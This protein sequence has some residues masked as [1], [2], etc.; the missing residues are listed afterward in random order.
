MA[1]ITQE[2]RIAE[3]NELNLFKNEVYSNLREMQTK[4][5]AKININH[6][7]LIDD[8]EEQSTKMNNLINNNKDMVLSMVSQKLN[9]EKIAE[10]ES[11]K[12]KLDSMII[13]HEV[14][15]KNNIEEISRIKF[16]ESGLSRFTIILDFLYKTI[17]NVIIM[18]YY[19]HK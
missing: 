15:I 10:L 2:S 16:G 3:K 7:K 11:F 14:R 9:L 18:V 17:Y 12:N 19:A 6:T 8:I 5:D 4:L 13:T 1:S